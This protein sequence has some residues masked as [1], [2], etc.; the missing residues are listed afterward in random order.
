[1]AS[2]TRYE[3]TLQNCARSLSD[4]IALQR[5]EQPDDFW[6]TFRSW[7]RANLSPGQG[8]KPKKCAVS[9]VLGP[10]WRADAV[11]RVLVRPMRRAQSRNAEASARE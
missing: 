9:R 4:F 7:V 1:M 11:S 3:R 6:P 8:E 5:E 2:P 10:M